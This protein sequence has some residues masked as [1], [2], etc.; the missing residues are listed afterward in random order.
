[1]VWS[2]VRGGLVRYQ[3]NPV[4]AVCKTARKS[5]LCSWLTPFEDPLCF[6]R[7]LLILYPSLRPF[8]SHSFP[9]P[10]LTDWSCSM[11][12]PV[13]FFSPFAVHL[14]P[15]GMRKLKLCVYW[16]HGWAVDLLYVSPVWYDTAAKSTLSSSNSILLL[17]EQTIFPPSVCL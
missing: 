4:P 1:M 5:F 7:L 6:S 2:W 15:F 10:G 3:E 12:V 14:H 13:I 11:W 16:K 17:E 9:D 8:F